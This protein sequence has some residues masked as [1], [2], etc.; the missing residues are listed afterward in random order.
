MMPQSGGN[1][2]GNGHNSRP[3]LTVFDIE[4]LSELEGRVVASD[5]HCY[6]CTA[7]QGSGCQGA[8]AA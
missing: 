2:S 5:A 7:G 6:G 8:T 4:D 1:G 3:P